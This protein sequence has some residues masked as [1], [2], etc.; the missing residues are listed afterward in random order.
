MFRSLSSLFARC[1]CD[2]LFINLLAKTGNR[3][4]SFAQLLGEYIPSP[5]T[6][7]IQFGKCA[8]PNFPPLFFDG[9]GV[10][11]IRFAMVDIYIP[12]FWRPFPPPAYCISLPSCTVYL[13]L[14]SSFFYVRVSP[15]FTDRVAWVN[16]CVAILCFP[17]TPFQ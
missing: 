8:Y 4:T 7:P 17:L 1:A 12:R 6:F 9:C 5:D 2:F 14:F 16:L 13:L 3:Q 15:L 10:M 11:A